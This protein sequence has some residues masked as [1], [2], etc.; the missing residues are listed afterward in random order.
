MTPGAYF[1]HS[2]KLLFLLFIAAHISFVLDEC[3]KIT[4]KQANFVFKMSTSRFEA[5]SVMVNNTLL[6]ITGGRDGDY[7]FL[8]SSE[9]IHTGCEQE[10]DPVPDK[11]TPFLTVFPKNLKILTE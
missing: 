2:T 5:A 6:W 11:F 8:S 10:M 9:F 7:N 3:Y 1:I 4:A